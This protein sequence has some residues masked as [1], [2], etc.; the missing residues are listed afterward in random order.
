MA[1]E[2]PNEPQEEPPASEGAQTGDGS[3]RPGDR[4]IAEPSSQD[5]ELRCGYCDAPLDEDQTYCLN[6]G[7]PTPRAPRLR[8]ARGAAAMIAIGL[9][10]LGAGSGVLAY[11]VAEDDDD[12]ADGTTT[13]ALTIPPAANAGDA[14]TTPTTPQP[15]T[16]E[17]DP[18][19]ETTDTGELPTDTTATDT[20]TVPEEPFPT[21]TGSD[22]E[23]PEETTGEPPSTPPEPGGVGDW[24]AGRTGWTAF[25]SSV[26]S[27]SDARA[28]A[29]RLESAGTPSGVLFSS[30]HPN[31]EPGFWVVFSGV[32]DAQGPAASRAGSL[33]DEFPGAYA[34]R[35]VS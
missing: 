18:F 6:C 2:E 11:F 12:A 30:D 35:V 9:V 8:S 31:L 24:P 4:K 14:G 7:S 29:A 25:L 3:W 1:E 20:V 22:P 19:P 33:T 28:A 5:G 16:V 15:G 34:R 27:E 10:V 23:P 17:T 21:V 13:T 26:R 32:F